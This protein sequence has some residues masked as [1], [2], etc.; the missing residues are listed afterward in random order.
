MNYGTIPNFSA[1]HFTPRATVSC[2]YSSRKVSYTPFAPGT[3][4]DG[5]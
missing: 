2:D 1:R 4:D 3:S 5:H